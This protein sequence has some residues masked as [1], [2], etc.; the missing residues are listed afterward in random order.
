MTTCDRAVRRLRTAC[1]KAKRDLSI[2]NT[3]TL[4]LEVLFGNVDFR[5]SITRARF[6]DLCSGLFRKVTQ[7]IEKVL[8]DAKIDKSQV[9]D[10]VLAGGSMRMPKMQQLLSS[11]F[12]ERYADKKLC[13]SIL[14]NNE[15]AAH[16]ATVMAALNDDTSPDVW[17]LLVLHVVPYSV[18]IETGGGVMTTVI[19]RNTTIPSKKSEEF[20]ISQPQ[21]PP[22][23]PTSFSYRDECT[24]DDS[25]DSNDE[26]TCNDSDD[27]DDNCCCTHYCEEHCKE[28]CGSECDHG[29]HNDIDFPSYPR[30]G[31][32]EPFIDARDNAIKIFTGERSMVRD[33][34]PLHTI[35]IHGFYDPT[36][37][38]DVTFDIDG[39]GLLT[40]IVTYTP[41]IGT[42]ETIVVK[43]DKG[44]LSQHDV[45]RLTTNFEAAA[46]DRTRRRVAHE[47]LQMYLIGG[48]YP[49]W[50]AAD[51][52][53]VLEW[54]DTISLGR[55]IKA[56]V[57]EIE[58]KYRI[59]LGPA[60]E[61]VD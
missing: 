45:K 53:E 16:G 51:A 43:L 41:H 5:S 35:A 58:A 46:D 36:A 21:S 19:S 47:Q 24:C 30:Y 33:N 37:R 32:K 55:H 12:G 44:Y 48:N 3:A 59:F 9:R 54:L 56:S 57:R 6:E 61:D 13:H 20:K 27:L 25:D 28:Y 1:E 7:P 38:S 49:Y 26:C 42:N 23:H 39:N 60:I 15:A 22:Y 14:N 29:G 18:G 40:A 17:H 31:P 2:S 11:F 4:E 34:T 52:V 10:V 8:R 50:R